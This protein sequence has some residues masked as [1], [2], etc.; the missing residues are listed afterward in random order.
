MEDKAERWMFTSWKR[1][2]V[3]LDNVQFLIFQTETCPKTKLEHYQGYIEFKKGYKLFQVK[4]LFKDKKMYVDKAREDR[5]R[6]IA[7]CSKL[8]SYN[9]HERFSY[10]SDHKYDHTYNHTYN[11]T[12]DY[13][14]DDVFDLGEHSEPTT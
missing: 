11:H 4:S 9:W 14:V 13:D 6:C 1:P 3:K 12:N 7:Y 10:A 5:Y 8:E 2:E